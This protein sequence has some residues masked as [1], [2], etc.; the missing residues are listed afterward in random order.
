M[1]ICKLHAYIFIFMKSLDH[2]TILDR[3][4]WASSEVQVKILILISKKHY[5]SLLVTCNFI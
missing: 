1:K 5:T 4:W 2:F 3:S